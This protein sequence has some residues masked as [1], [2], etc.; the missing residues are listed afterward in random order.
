MAIMRTLITVIVFIFSLQ[1]LTKAD[2]IRDF[3]IEGMSIGDSLLDFFSEE[4]INNFVNYDNLPSDMK[5]RIA[6]FY[7][8]SDMEMNRY[9]GM[10]IYYKPEDKKFIL[11]GLA[12]HIICGKK[13]KIECNNVYAEI[14]NSISSNFKN[15][16]GEEQTFKH[17]DDKSGKSIVTAYSINLY[18]GSIITVTYT[19]WSNEVE[20]VDNVSV[21]VSTIEVNNWIAKGYGTK[22]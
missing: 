20:C 2:D 16:K 21:D 18:N 9:D 1:S 3:K 12:G 15:L 19:D 14:V 5:F 17:I 6:E 11:H 10:Q 13:N 7:S 8:K 4:K 22:E